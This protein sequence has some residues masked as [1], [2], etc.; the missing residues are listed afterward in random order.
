MENIEKGVRS[1]P[2]DLETDDAELA[3]SLGFSEIEEDKEE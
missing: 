1:I 2:V 3:E